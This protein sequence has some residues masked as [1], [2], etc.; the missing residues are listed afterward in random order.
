MKRILVATDFSTRSDRATRRA[1]LLAKRF[2]ADLVL[3]H[4]L[5]DDQPT[6][7]LKAERREA[8]D[9]LS[10]LSLSLNRDD[11]LSCIYRLAEGEAFL[12][13][14][15]TA[16]DAEVDLIVIG[17]HRRQLLQ[18]IFVGTTAERI[19]RNSDVPVLMANGA[20]AGQYRKVMLA[21]D[22]TPASAD[23]VR[24]FQR[25]LT[26]HLHASEIMYAFPAPAQSQMRRAMLDEAAV[27][28]YV[29][30]EEDTARE[31]LAKFMREADVLNAKP[32]L[33]VNE[34]KAAY[35][36]L[37]AA[38]ASNIDLLAIGV[39]SRTGLAKLLLGSTAENILASAQIDI[40][41]IPPG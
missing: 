37:A 11:G 39:R 13:I 31:G 29:A 2:Q 1:T 36:I 3:A 30:D 10:Q 7:K 17:P 16:R 5:D 4:V 41:A 6:R 24:Q 35:T 20:P 9:L 15:Q 23:V 33:R 12:G 22:L 14:L 38:A 40:L 25:L 18:D 32:V 8:E 21:T 19:I 27:G 34:T 26:P 28:D